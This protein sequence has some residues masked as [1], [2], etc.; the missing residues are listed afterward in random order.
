VT[1]TARVQRMLAHLPL[2]LQGGK[3]LAAVFRAIAEELTVAESGVTRLMRSRWY[4]IN[5]GWDDP[6]A[7]VDAK[8]ATELGALAA[9]FDLEPVDGETTEHF[10]RRLHDV[11]VLHRA[12]LTTA[13]AL[14]QMAANVYLSDAPPQISWT[15]DA[16]AVADF[17]V[18]EPGAPP[19]AVRLELVDNP[20]M[21]AV[22]AQQVDPAA[23]FDI[24]NSGFD[25]AIPE[26]V[27]TAGAAGLAVPVITQVETDLRII[28]VGA[29]E[30]GDELTLRHEQ[31]PLVNGR[32]VAAPVIVVNPYT[33]G[34]PTSYESLFWQ[35]K[36]VK[37]VK[38]ATG[39][40]FSVFE[41]ASVLPALRTGASRWRYENL[42]LALLDRYLSYWPDRDAL[43]AGLPNLPPAPARIEY[44]WPEAIAAC[45]SLR[46]PTDYVP[47]H[48]IRDPH[49]SPPRD[50][51]VAEGRSRLVRALL[52]V[53]ADGRA[54]G[55]EA[56]LELVVP[57]RH[58]ALDVRDHDPAIGVRIDHAEPLPVDE[59]FR[60]GGPVIHLTDSIETPEER[61]S[62]TGFF[63]Q[64]VFDTSLYAKPKATP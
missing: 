24:I 35:E 28:W 9:L 48:M 52:R 40:R 8:A 61:L 20:P 21:V 25:P 29:L 10:R 2:V 49:H 45:F 27:V 11:I 14:L 46:I 1:P 16:T 44:R 56:R 13:P 38:T 37:G 59:K 22:Q 26:I 62:T 53:L 12:G 39:A 19:R 30:P 31:L 43:A 4:A 18:T 54:A 63:D 50:V 33:Y 55:I 36:T 34:E 64:T 3:N 17:T 7:E 32:P 42:P 41:R 15:P 6:D 57:R 58:E 5:R 60:P 47:W 51:A 23:T